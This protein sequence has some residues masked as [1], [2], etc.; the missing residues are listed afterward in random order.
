MDIQNLSSFAS[1][2]HHL[3]T[4]KWQYLSIATFPLLWRIRRNCAYRSVLTISCSTSPFL[5]QFGGIIFTSAHVH[6]TLRFA[7]HCVRLWEYRHL[8]QVV[9]GSEEL[10]VL[11]GRKAVSTKLWNPVREAGL[12]KCTGHGS[13]TEPMVGVIC[14]V[15]CYGRPLPERSQWSAWVLTIE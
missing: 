12:E 10:T 7:R 15:N 8:I 4:S 5:F 3:L 11:L 13:G 1:F 2:P 9:P 14:S 6:W